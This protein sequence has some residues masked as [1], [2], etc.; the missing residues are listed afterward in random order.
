MKLQKPRIP[1][2]LSVTSDLR[3]MFLAEDGF[4]GIIV[5]GQS[6]SGVDVTA[7]DIT[8]SRCDN[9]D[10]T[11][12]HLERLTVSDMQFVKCTFVGTSVSN[13]GWQRIEINNSLLVGV[14]LQTSTLQHVVFHDCKIDTVNLRASKLQ[15]VLFDNCT[16]TD[17]DLYSANLENVSFTNCKINKVECSSVAMRQVDLSKSTI[18]DIR[19]ISGLK[20]AT[21]SDEQ[22][23]QLSPYFASE[24]GIKVAESC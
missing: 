24:L 6:L 12:A 8:E 18:E 9:V 10:L 2:Q 14:E 16:L 3:D 23:L 15:Y 20:G 13:S 17:L 22:L 11:G 19:G 7:A 5:A 21:I 4:D 1:T